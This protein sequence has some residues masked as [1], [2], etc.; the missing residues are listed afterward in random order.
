VEF[1]CRSKYTPSQIS[2]IPYDSF[3]RRIRNI[4]STKNKFSILA[5]YVQIHQPSLNVMPDETVR[6]TCEIQYGT[7]VARKIPSIFWFEDIYNVKS[8]FFLLNLQ[9]LLWIL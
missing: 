1:T 5:D 2:K 8:F 7:K 6:L 3:D 4:S 9:P